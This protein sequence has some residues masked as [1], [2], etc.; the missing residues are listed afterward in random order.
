[1]TCYIRSVVVLLI[2]LAVPGCV[3][4][5]PA[6]MEGDLI[7]HESLS[8]QGAALKAATGS[9]YT[10]M[11]IIFKERTGWFVFEAVQPVKAT[12]LSL[13]IRRGKNRHYVIKRLKNRDDILNRKTIEKMKRIGKHFLGKNYDNR[14]LWSDRTIYCSELVYKLYKRGAGVGIGKL[15]KLKDFNL[16][17]RAVKKLMKIRYGTKV[18]YGEPVISPVSMFESSKLVT[19]RKG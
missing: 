8:S 18:P 12:P 9:R 7:F 2:L 17:H 4:T 19:V 15:Q 1:M 13:W 10:H 5:S 11:G 16:E 6:I 14:F 3:K